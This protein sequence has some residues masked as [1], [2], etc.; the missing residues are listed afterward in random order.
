VVKSDRKM[1]RP[2]TRRKPLTVV[3]EDGGVLAG[4]GF[5]SP[6]AGGGHRWRRAGRVGR[7]HGPFD[8]MILIWLAL[9]LLGGK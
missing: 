2:R 1:G 9:P 3:V 5:G 7:R 8:M 6:G 4:S